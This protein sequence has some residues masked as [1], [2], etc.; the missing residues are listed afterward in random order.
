MLTNYLM[1]KKSPIY[2]SSRFWATLYAGVLLI[3]L[4][5]QFIFGYLD[6]YGIVVKVLNQNLSLPIPLACWLWTFV[7]SLFCGFDRF[8][9]IKNTQQLTSGQ[10]S[11]GDLPKLRKI[12]VMALF[13]FIYALICSL[14]V[15]RDF[16]LEA[17]LSAFGSSVIIYI[18]GNKLVKANR[19]VC[20]DKDKDGIP[21]IVQKEYEKWVR[22]QK[23]LGT[24]K[25]FLDLEYFLDE[26]P[27]LAE[28]LEQSKGSSLIKEKEGNK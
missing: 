6:K 15:D 22:E 3:L 14:F 16:Q 10:I 25:S 9:D 4:T 28:K 7:I 20:E 1:N 17:L 18:S 8:V 26:R 2:Y 21:D 23:K 24:D 12:I 19:Y 13:I 27:D 11:I 5:L